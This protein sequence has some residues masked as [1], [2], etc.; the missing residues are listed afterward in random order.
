MIS[1]DATAETKELL[2]R[3]MMLLGRPADA[4]PLW[5]GLFDL[6]TPAFDP[7]NLLNCAGQLQ[8]DDVILEACD[9]LHERGENDWRLLDFELSYLQKYDMDAAVQRLISFIAARPDHRLAK[10][11][12]SLIG[13]IDNRPELVRASLEDLPRLDELSPDDVVRAVQVLKFGGEPDKAVEYAYGYLREHFGN[14]EAHKAL[15]LSMMPGSFSPSV[16]PTLDRIAPGAAVCF[17]EQ[18]SELR[19]VVLEN[20]AEPRAEFEEMSLTSPLAQKLLGKGVGD[21]VT[22]AKESIQDRIAHDSPYTSEI[23]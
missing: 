21:T 12:L 23:C 2:A 4:L 6:D 5:Q 20:T 16:P 3:L 7:G 22:I 17:Q 8:R 18:G 14:V 15:V 9:R 1:P 13:L 19:W 11:A 10:L